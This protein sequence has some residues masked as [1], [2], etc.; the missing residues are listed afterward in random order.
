M[1][2]G[3]SKLTGPVGGVKASVAASDSIPT[4]FSGE[5]TLYAALDTDFNMPN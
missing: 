5:R 3:I 4:M 2:M 1:S